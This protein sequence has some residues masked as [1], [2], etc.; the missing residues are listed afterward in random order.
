MLKHIIYWIKSLGRRQKQILMIFADMLLLPFSFWLSV[1]LQF[2]Y[3]PVNSY[4]SDNWAFFLII[5][6]SMI[7]MFIHYGLYR[8]VLKYMGYQVILATVKSVSV[9][10]IFLGLIFIFSNE[11]LLSQS[12][13]VIFW[14]VTI[15]NIIASR[16]LMKSFLYLN[17][18]VK[19][20]IAIYGAGQAGA[21]LIN[22]LRVSSEFIPIALFDDDPA[23]WGTVVN[24]VWVYAPSEIEDVIEKNNIGIILVGILGISK[25]ERKIILQRI[26]DYPVQ[27]RMISSIEN[28]IS[29]NFNLRSIRSVEVED[30]LGRDIVKPNEKLLSSNL[31]NKNILVTGAGG[32]IGRELCKQ[33]V[34]LNPRKIIILENNEYAL[35]KVQMEIK[36]YASYIR[37]IP[38]LSSVLDYIHLKDIL[39]NNQIH[40]VYHAAAYKHVPLVENN[41]LDGIKNNIL[42]TYYCVKASLEAN[43]DNFILISTDKAVRPA[44]IMGATKR[45]SELILQGAQRVSSGTCFSIVR[46]GNVLNSAGSVVPLFKEQIQKGGPITVT[47]PDV[48][49]YFM[50]IPEAVELVI[51]AGAMARG[52][53]VFVLE[54]GEPIRIYDLAIKMI[55]LSG[56]QHKDNRNIHGDIEI[57]ISGLRQGEKIDEELIIGNNVYE[58]EHPQILK[59]EEKFISWEKIEELSI[60]LIKFCET[61]ELSSVLEILQQAVSDWKPAQDI[62]LYKQ[63]DVDLLFD[64]NSDV[65]EC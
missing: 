7:P 37:I 4:W 46:F 49:R 51:Q 48:A 15:L 9:S 63:N 55:H 50:S 56:Y 53:E 47:H 20:S 3:I 60:E 23:K 43:I 59:A 1:S 18:P 6:V 54:M 36:K 29:G 34:N 61:R 22:N 57:K 35:Y 39:M 45:Y 31:K 17:E 28:L 13:I 8:A 27:V 38:V 16:Y 19:K 2:G 14:F 10:C 40:T 58:T 41:P 26:S 12:A 42:G 33:I 62:L 11:L 25:E 52:G 64:K 32:S 21:Q 30:I 5:I 24:S 44:N 65:A